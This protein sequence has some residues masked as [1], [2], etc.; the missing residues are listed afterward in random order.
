MLFNS[1]IFLRSKDLHASVNLGIDNFVVKNC[2]RNVKI[3]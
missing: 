1:S 3:V 2:S